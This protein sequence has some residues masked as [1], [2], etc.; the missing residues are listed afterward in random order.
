[1]NNRL[2]ESIYRENGQKYVL[3]DKFPLLE[4]KVN[5]LINNHAKN[6][7][8]VI[9]A[10]RSNLS[11]EENLQRTDDLKQDLKDLGWSYT[12]SYGGGF[13]EKI[14]DDGTKGFDVDKPQFN[15]ISFVVYN[16][17]RFGDRDLLDDAIALCD[18]YEQDDIYYQEPNGKAYWYNK[19]GKKDAA[20][21]CMTKNDAGQMY[22]TGFGGSKLSKKTRDIYTKK[23][24]VSNAKAV[25]HR[26]SGIMEAVA[27]PAASRIEEI[28]RSKDGEVFIST[29]NVLSGKEVYNIL[30]S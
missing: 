7:F 20:F 5:R 19:D 28:K 25:D 30:N 2:F 4:D 12:I 13:T 3:L 14:A 24:K 27:L 9:S 18:K 16:Y 17:N 21:S 10:C 26:F 23:H 11:P 1:M 15:E 8:A 22:F 29:Y 6:G